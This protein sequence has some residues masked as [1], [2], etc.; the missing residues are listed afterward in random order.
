VAVADS[1]EIR[2]ALLGLLLGA[3]LGALIG[4]MGR[5]GGSGR[6]S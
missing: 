3:A 1:S 4:L 2:R 5:R 6:A